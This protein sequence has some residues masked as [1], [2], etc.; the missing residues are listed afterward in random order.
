MDAYTPPSLTTSVPLDKMEIRVGLTCFL[1]HLVNVCWLGAFF[2]FLQKR[3][4]QNM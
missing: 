3:G 4:M 1:E 2:L